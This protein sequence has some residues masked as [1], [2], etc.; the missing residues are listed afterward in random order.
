MP[1]ERAWKPGNTLECRPSVE[2]SSTISLGVSRV[3]PE[4]LKPLQ[5]STLLEKFIF[6]CIGGTKIGMTRIQSQAKSSRS[7]AKWVITIVF[8]KMVNNKHTSS[9]S[10]F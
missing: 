7:N 2:V 3:S 8:K 4:L 6:K 1:T 5:P 10:T 9:L